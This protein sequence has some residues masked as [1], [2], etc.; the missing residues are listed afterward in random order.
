MPI[1]RVSENSM[2]K[3]AETT[4][5]Q[6]RLLERRDLQRLLKADI[7]VLSPELM[8]IAEEYG[9]W[10]DSSR[11]IDLL[12]LDKQASLVVV[13]LKRSEDG[14]HMELQAIRYA[15]MV[16]SM[17]FDQLVE[18]H[19]RFIGGEEAH[20]KAESAI[21]SFLGW[22]SPSEG[23]LSGDVKIML[24]AANFS[25]ELTTAVLW[26]NK[27]DL[28]ITCIRMKP[29]RLD[30]QVLVDVQ[31]I[32]PVPEATVYETKIR[33]QQQESRRT[34]SAR[35]EIFLRFWAQLIERSR[36]KT[37]VVANRRTRDLPDVL[38]DPAPAF[39]CA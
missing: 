14:G 15:A 22:D 16:S 11:R 36:T 20:Q 10:E 19:A 3:V 34:K 9:D 25:I 37:S 21:L 35:Q 26:L 32:I 31:Q 5:S 33:A 38:G 28:D 17:T 8:V 1:Y 12:C 30:T 24:V 27:H 7:S 2:E 39:V 4:F 18:A 6:E 23:S 29:H 13:E